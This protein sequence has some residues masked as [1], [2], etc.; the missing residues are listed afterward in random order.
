MISGYYVALSKVSIFA[1]SKEPKTV[2]MFKY[3]AKLPIH[4]LKNQLPDPY[5]IWGKFSQYFL[6]QVYLPK[7]NMERVRIIERALQ[8]Q[9]NNIK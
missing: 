8:N 5:E 2:A 3:F 1:V 4:T 9:F 7:S 6:E